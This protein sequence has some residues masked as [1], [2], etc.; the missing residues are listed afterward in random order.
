MKIDFENDIVIMKYN[1]NYWLYSNKRDRYLPTDISD[2]VNENVVIDSINNIID[3]ITEND[4][5]D[6]I[7]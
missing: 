6:Y 4:W 7:I 1:H 2:D 3:F 5:I